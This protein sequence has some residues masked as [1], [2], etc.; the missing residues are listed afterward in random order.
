MPDYLD[1]VLFFSV[2]S[3]SNR[4]VCAF[5]EDK[6]TIDLIADAIIEIAYHIF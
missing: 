3:A 4:V 5:D 6:L 1:G 2:S